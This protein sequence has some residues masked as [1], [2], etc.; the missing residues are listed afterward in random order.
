MSGSAPTERGDETKSGT[1]GVST[2]VGE[3]YKTWAI[4]SRAVCRVGTRLELVDPLCGHV[5]SSVDTL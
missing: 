4:V 1:E 5:F 3:G 2:G